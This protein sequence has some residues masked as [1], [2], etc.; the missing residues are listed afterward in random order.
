MPIYRIQGKSVLFI[1]V[2]KTGGTSV[3]KYLRQQGPEGLHNQG[4]KLVKPA[5][6][7][8]F[9][10]NVPLQHFH[11][12]LLQAVFAPGFF[13]YA[14]IIVR[15]PVERMRSAYLHSRALG[16]PEGLLSFDAWA[17][18]M[19]PLASRLP[20][21]RNNHLRPQVEFECFGAEVFRF[22]Q[23]IAAIMAAVAGR[24]GLEP[25]AEVPHERRGTGAALPVSA[26]TREYLRAHF[27]L[28]CA[29]FGY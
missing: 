18:L 21:L 12:E 16:R 13:D 2:P 29:R 9:S 1:H 15:D 27:G 7:G 8:A 23:G 3:E 26:S 19:L 4:T 17:R 25:P 10:S 28:D 14:F 22:E 20:Y 5:S 11:A 24:L 6:G